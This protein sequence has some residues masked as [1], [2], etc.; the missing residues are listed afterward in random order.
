MQ[1]IHPYKAVI[2]FAAGTR[3]LYDF[4]DDNPM[5]EASRCSMSTIR[6][7]LPRNTKQVAI[8]AALGVDLTGQICA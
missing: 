3:H 4:M 5:I 8:N 1:T 2:A 7:L 6:Q